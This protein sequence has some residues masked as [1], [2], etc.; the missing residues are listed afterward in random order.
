MKKNSKFIIY[1]SRVKLI[2]PLI[3]ISKKL[4]IKESFNYLNNA[5]RERVAT[6]K[7]DAGMPSV[8][9]MFDC[10]R[11][12]TFIQVR[13]ILKNLLNTFLNLFGFN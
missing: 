7:N 8:H 3:Q 12:D 9:G 13:I 10:H 6:R 5:C 11:F 4:G 2:K 1:H